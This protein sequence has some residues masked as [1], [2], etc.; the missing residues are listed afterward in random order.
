LKV[1][2]G[3]VLFRAD[4][5]FR[6]KLG[7]SQQRSLPMAGSLDL[8]SGVLT[9]VHFTMPAKPAEHF[10]VNNAWALLQKNA[11]AG[12]V[13]NTYNDGPSEPGAKALGGFYELETLSPTRP[14]APKET[15]AHSHRTFHIKADGDN[16]ERLVKATLNVDLA[17]V[18]K[19]LATP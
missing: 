8:Q 14:L 9:L 19:F 15:I 16:L 18:K 1:T 11:Y 3:A 7:V 2:P 17:E 6:A 12:D 10:Y 4:G 13:F 5:K